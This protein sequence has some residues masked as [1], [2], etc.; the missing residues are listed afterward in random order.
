MLKTSVGEW[1][2]GTGPESDIVMSSRVR[3]ARNL[4]HYPFVGRASETER[5]EIEGFLRSHLKKTSVGSRLE[6]TN[7]GG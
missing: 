5:S 4:A 3:L 6:Y 1:L 2:K 7:L